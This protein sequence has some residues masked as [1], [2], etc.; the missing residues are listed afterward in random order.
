VIHRALLRRNGVFLV[1]NGAAPVGAVQIDEQNSE[2][3]SRDRDRANKI[4]IPG[5]A[6][7]RCALCLAFFPLWKAQSQIHPAQRDTDINSAGQPGRT[8]LAGGD[9]QKT[10]MKNKLAL[11]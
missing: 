9:E 8:E 10:V 2:P 11:V 1:K 6:Y 5:R 7:A 4:F 3:G